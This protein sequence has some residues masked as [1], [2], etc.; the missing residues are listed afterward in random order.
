MFLVLFLLQHGSQ[1]WYQHHLAVTKWR[2]AMVKRGGRF[3][4]LSVGVMLAYS[5]SLYAH[6]EEEWLAPFCWQ[7]Q[8]SSQSVDSNGRK[9]PELIIQ[10]YLKQ[11]LIQEER[12]HLGISVGLPVVLAPLLSIGI[13]VP[14]YSVPHF[15]FYC[16]ELSWQQVHLWCHIPNMH[17][18]L[19]RWMSQSVSISIS[20][21]S[22]SQQSS[23][24][25]QHAM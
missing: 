3:G 10:K 17:R 21:N 9:S 8:W 5:N 13:L 1:Y 18:F 15:Y 12:F 6:Q 20:S 22:H 14:L 19:F 25:H 24:Y 7:V 11:L 16:N 2:C 4:C 23:T